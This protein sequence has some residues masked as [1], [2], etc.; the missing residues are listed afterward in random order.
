M[1]GGGCR[2]PKDYQLSRPLAQIFFLLI[3]REG[4]G[5]EKAARSGVLTQHSRKQQF[6]QLLIVCHTRHQ[7]EFFSW[8]LPFYSCASPGRLLYAL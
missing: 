1:G 3:Q 5:V 2:W 4:G 8:H 6:S 7:S